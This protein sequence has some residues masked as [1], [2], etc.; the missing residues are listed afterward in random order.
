MDS[1]SKSTSK[2]AASVVSASQKSFWQAVT[3]GD[4]ETVQCLLENEDVD[5][6]MYDMEGDQRQGKND[7]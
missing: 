6:N 3:V 7:M 1:S 4:L 5:V 2:S